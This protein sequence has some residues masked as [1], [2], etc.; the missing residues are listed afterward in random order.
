MWPYGNRHTKSLCRSRHQRYRLR[1]HRFLKGRFVK[2]MLRRER[3]FQSK[4]R[5]RL[6]ASLSSNGY[7][8]GPA[9]DGSGTKIHLPKLRLS[10]GQKLPV[11]FQTEAAECGLACLAMV[12]G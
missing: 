2:R 1:K 12:A 6:D 8:N 5:S 3:K 4:L 9:L 10:W 11:V 7:S